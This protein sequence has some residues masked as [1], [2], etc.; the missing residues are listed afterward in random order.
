MCGC[1][2]CVP[3]TGDLACNLGMYPDWELNWQPFSS[4]AG[5]QSTEPREPGMNW[6][7]FCLWVDAQPTEPHWLRPSCDALIPSKELK[8]HEAIFK[9]LRGRG[10]LTHPL[11][12][13][14]GLHNPDPRPPPCDIQKPSASD[15][16][17]SQASSPAL[18][19]PFLWLHFCF[20]QG[21]TDC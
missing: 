13:P 16:T 21:E 19:T 15:L 2:S 4:Q 11:T 1:L 12:Y 18:L 9:H 3:H 5:A 17:T 10:N 14:P 6:Q 8:C 20:S 7:P